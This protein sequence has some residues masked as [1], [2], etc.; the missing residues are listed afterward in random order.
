M[1]WKENVRSWLRRAQKESANRITPERKRKRRDTRDWKLKRSHIFFNLSFVSTEQDSSFHFF[2]KTKSSQR[3]SKKVPYTHFKFSSFHDTT[4]RK[5]SNH[6][7]LSSRVGA[8]HVGCWELDSEDVVVVMP[9][10]PDG[11][12]QLPDFRSHVG[13][14]VRV[15]LA[16]MDPAVDVFQMLRKDVLCARN[17]E[18]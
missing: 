10:L 14:T 12:Q 11:L 9:V 7:E 2:H 17:L 6:F 1:Q 5:V 8:D 3:W 13:P 4:T 16:R 15:G 18:T